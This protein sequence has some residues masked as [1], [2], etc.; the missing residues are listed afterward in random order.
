MA[1]SSSTST[2]PVAATS[3]SS[4]DPSLFSETAAR[5][6]RRLKC[7]EAIKR[8]LDDDSLENLPTISLALSGG[9]TRAMVASASVFDAFSQ[10]GLLD[11]I[12]D[13]AALSGSTWFLS[14]YFSGL[15]GS[16]EQHP[17]HGT[18]SDPWVYGG[19]YHPSEHVYSKL[20]EE[21]GI[22]PPVSKS[23][24]VK[25]LIKIGDRTSLLQQ[26]TSWMSEVLLPV[27]SNPVCAINDIVPL[28]SSGDYPLPIF[29]A[30]TPEPYSQKVW[31]EITPWTV[32]TGDKYDIPTSQFPS[33][34]FAE[35]MG[36]CGSAFASDLDWAKTNSPRLHQFLSLFCKNDTSGFY[37]TFS[38]IFGKTLRYRV[39][40]DP[41]N[42]PQL[43]VDAG[44]HHNLPL[45]PFIRTHHGQATSLFRPVD[46]L[47][48]VESSMDS[49][50]CEEFI[51]VLESGHYKI[52]DSDR[53][54]L[55]QPFS[56]DDP[57][58]IFRPH[59]EHLHLPIIL[60]FAGL[61]HKSSFDFRWTVAEVLNFNQ[62]LVNFICSLPFQQ[63]L[64]HV[65]AKSAAS[66]ARLAYSPL[67]LTVP[68]G[69]L[70]PLQRQL[71]AYFAATYP[72][73]ALN[74]THF[75]LTHP[76][77]HLLVLDIQ[78]ERRVDSKDSLISVQQLLLQNL[79]S[80]VRKTNLVALEGPAGSGKSTI[81]RLLV[82]EQ[83]WN[84]RFSCNI[85]IDLELLRRYCEKHERNV[86]QQFL[87]H[88]V[89]QQD[90]DLAQQVCSCS[91][92][93]PILWIFDAYDQA[94]HFRRKTPFDHFLFQLSQANIP[95]ITYAIVSSRHERRCHFNT[96]DRF[97]PRPWG[98]YEAINYINQFF[99]P[100]PTPTSL[101][102]RDKALQVFFGPPA[103]PPT[104]QGSI[105]GPTTPWDNLT[106]CFSLGT[107]LDLTPLMCEIVCSVIK[108]DTIL[109]LD[110]NTLYDQVFSL[111]CEWGKV[112][113]HEWKTTIYQQA[114]SV[115]TSDDSF[116]S[117]NLCP[118]LKNSGFF[119]QNP[120]NSSQFRFRHKTLSEF[121]ASQHIALSIPTDFT[122]VRIGALFEHQ[123]LFLRFLARSFCQKSNARD[124]HTKTRMLLLDH[125]LAQFQHHYITHA[126]Q[127]DVE[128]NAHWNSSI[129]RKAWTLR[130]GINRIVDVLEIWN[131]AD[132]INHCFDFL[133][134]LS[135]NRFKISTRQWYLYLFFEAAARFHCRILFDALRQSQLLP[136][137]TETDHLKHA[138]L[139]TY[140]E[141]HRNYEFRMYLI[142]IGAPVM[143]LSLAL[144]DGNLEAS[145][146]ILSRALPWYCSECE[147]ANSPE[148]GRCHHCNCS[149]NEQNVENLP[150]DWFAGILCGFLELLQS[151]HLHLSV[152]FPKMLQVLNFYQNRSGWTP[153][154]QIELTHHAPISLS[155]D[156]RCT[157]VK[158]LHDRAFEWINNI[159]LLLFGPASIQYIKELTEMQEIPT[160]LVDTLHFHWISH[161]SL[162][163]T[164]VQCLVIGIQQPLPVIRSFGSVKSWGSFHS[165]E[166]PRPK[167][168]GEASLCVTHSTFPIVDLS[169][170]QFP[171]ISDIVLIL[172]P[173]IGPS[174]L[175]QV[176]QALRFR[177]SRRQCCIFIIIYSETT[178]ETEARRQI[179]GLLLG[180]LLA[181][182]TRLPVYS[183]SLL[184]STSP[185]GFDNATCRILSRAFS[186]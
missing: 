83:T 116:L 32:T 1:S 72:R 115:F 60:Y 85:L 127:F 2:S 170:Q 94:E 146:R 19:R 120:T 47:L 21:R 34:S 10:L 26:Y 118:A 137:V 95:W 51:K 106:Q 107:E 9:S 167:I 11:C 29:T 183:L 55:E 145:D 173:S 62:Q 52:R 134:N 12:T 89:F 100:D 17:F 123:S 68:V 99:G 87:L 54:Q 113:E 18:D 143:T 175:R 154:I 148:F 166:F 79:W 157:I 65:I 124:S 42:P 181:D 164:S 130:F 101:L 177:I 141:Y 121:A 184:D 73:I 36:I 156:D 81:C 132:L 159:P 122:R 71:T 39:Q 171:K 15:L 14:R 35:L 169:I 45:W 161:Q 97:A 172:P 41:P 108:P 138:L 135:K 104:P 49:K 88:F 30:M 136:L 75:I 5:Q 33:R 78:I 109:P 158:V 69:P 117:I 139:A 110:M 131:Q 82:H 179:S 151:K 119:E 133:R 28:L 112:S 125:L 142:S 96:S 38:S 144:Y 176:L 77:S 48:V 91:P 84:I 6:V 7:Q 152:L 64:R 102:L 114:F 66:L 27:N 165:F 140:D 4:Y 160:N 150:S 43:L 13:V 57:F 182:S 53:R 44:L 3:G 67:S 185:S 126:K 168:V 56:H 50:G 111:F 40:L 155:F 93:K 16:P 61:T 129:V 149:R 162:E 92:D 153:D 63:K 24:F 98:S 25:R 86:D 128:M 147:S 23:A 59:H 178:L 90:Q 76:N 105:T 174:F 186:Y 74:N 31:T 46:I 8:F 70:S 58:K 80:V 180:S 22:G 163:K 20:I 37:S 103:A